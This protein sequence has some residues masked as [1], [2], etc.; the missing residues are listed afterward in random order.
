MVR[1]F[2]LGPTLATVYRMVMTKER[3]IKASAV[4]NDHHSMRPEVVEP[5]WAFHRRSRA[6]IR[7]NPTMKMDGKVK[8]T[9]WEDWQVAGWSRHGAT[10]N[11]F[12][13]SG[14]TFAHFEPNWTPNSL[15]GP[16]CTTN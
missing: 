12:D 13:P 4:P 5:L 8:E 11:R 1:T 2:R 9:Q 10:C 3:K 16:V 7:E 14:F 15:I 6:A